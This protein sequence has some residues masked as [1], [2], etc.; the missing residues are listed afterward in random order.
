MQK[1]NRVSRSL[2][3]S[4]AIL[5]SSFW[6]V[7]MAP[8]ADIASTE[9]M[10]SPV[11]GTGEY[12]ELTNV[13]NSPIDLTGWSQDD[14]NRV[15]GTHPLDAFGVVLPG[16]SV[17][18]TEGSDLGLFRTYWKFSASVKIIA[19]GSSDNIGRSDEIN[20]Y[21]NVGTPIDRLTYSD[22]D[23]GGLRTQGTSANIELSELFLNHANLAVASLVGDSYLS[24]RGG[25]GAGDL[26]NPGLYTP[27][28]SVPEPASIAILIL[29][30][31]VI[32]VFGTHRRG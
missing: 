16:E 23:I 11:D 24:Y 8:A 10:Y 9:W 22:Q 30:S 28:V 27:F 1:W 21:D 7:Q 2:I 29:D 6:L 5:T 12:F 31:T 17:F 25:G 20:L 13:G 14:N 3:A 4:V 18:G 32:S 15:P 26:G 19:H